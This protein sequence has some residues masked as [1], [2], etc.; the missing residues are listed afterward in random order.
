MIDGWVPGAVKFAAPGTQ[1]TIMSRSSRLRLIEALT[2][3]FDQHHAEL[4]AMLLDQ[5]DTLTAKIDTITLRVEQLLTDIPAADDSATAPLGAV[6]RLDEITRIGMMAA[7]TVIAEVDLNMSQFPAARHVVSCDDPCP[8][9]CVV[10]LRRSPAVSL[11]V[12]RPTRHRTTSTR[13]RTD[14]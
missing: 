8:A 12:R 13:T 1:A 9:P 7:L 5:V 2:G 3:R 14:R 4:I 10:R 6:A 11:R